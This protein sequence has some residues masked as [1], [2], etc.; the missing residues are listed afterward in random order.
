MEFTKRENVIVLRW[1][2]CGTPEVASNI[3]EEE[4]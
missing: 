3:S 2:S 1:P 4:L